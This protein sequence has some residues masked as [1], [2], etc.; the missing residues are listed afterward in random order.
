MA[1]LGLLL[2]LAL[3]P[4]A[5]TANYSKAPTMTQLKIQYGLVNLVVAAPGDPHHEE[6]LPRILPAVDLAVRAVISPDGPL[7]NWQFKVRHR[8]SQ[9]S[10]TYGPIAAIDFYFNKTAGNTFKIFFEFLFCFNARG[11]KYSVILIALDLI[12]QL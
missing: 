1:I 3:T 8:D 6:S 2:S 4:I 12:T 11:L 5:M 9:C 7:P 10:S